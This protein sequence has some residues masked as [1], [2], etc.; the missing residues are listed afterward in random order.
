MALTST[1]DVQSRC[2]HC[3]K[4]LT[5]I[6][7]KLMDSEFVVAYA[8]C[9]CPGATAEREERQS[10]EEE[11]ERAE[12]A[13]RRRKAYIRA[14]VKPRFLDAE[15]PRAAGILADVKR[16]IG[17]Y[18]CGPVGTGKTHLASAVARLTVDGGLSVKMTDMLGI[19]AALKAT[20]GGDGTEDDVLHRLTRCG[21]LIVDDLGKEAPTEWTLGQVF[22][23]INARYEALKPVIVTTQFSKADLARRLSRHGDRETAEAIVSRLSEMCTKVEMTG[24][25]RRLR[26]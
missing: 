20:Y 8:P 5:P 7:A 22:R 2:P 10:R 24:A 12:L 25:D 1:T 11:L 9:D 3:G 6:T 13:E 17:A 14:G 19:L 26:K 16:G 23:V 18:I 21:L 15:S 4:E